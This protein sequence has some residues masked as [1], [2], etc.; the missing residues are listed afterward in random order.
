MRPA[1]LDRE[2]QHKRHRDQQGGNDGETPEY[3]D[4]GDIGTGLA[5]PEQRSGRCDFHGA[6]LPFDPK[7]HN[8][9]KHV[10]IAPHGTSDRYRICQ[11]QVHVV[12]FV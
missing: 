3:I 11:R 10:D 12:A 6:R 7:S 5:T 1:M 8:F 9:Q 2:Q 4:I